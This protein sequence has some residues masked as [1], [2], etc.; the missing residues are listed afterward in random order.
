MPG[1]A[2]EYTAG[3]FTLHVDGNDIAWTLCYSEGASRKQIVVS[4]AGVEVVAPPGTPMEGPGGIQD[5]VQGRRRSILEA[6]QR[7]DAQRAA[8]REQRYSSG[9]QVLYRGRRLTLRVEQD[10]VEEAVVSYRS[11]FDVRVPRGLGA[12][13]QQEAVR[14][15]LLAWMIDH[16]RRDSL[17]WAAFYGGR[18]GVDPAEVRLVADETRWGS[19]SA[20]GVVRINWRLVEAP[21]PAMEY[22]VAHEA[23]HL[24]EPQHTERFWVTLREAMPDWQ[25]GKGLLEQW[26]RQQHLS[27][28][29]V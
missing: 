20:E 13:E 9:A 4:T 23:V 18:V 22:V 2:T 12:D 19:C 27:P 6:V 11:R 1:A 17:R 10:D 29:E 7:I 21:S 14:R 25:E 26:E 16:A 5:F 24:R 15:A 8:A 3:P 28:R